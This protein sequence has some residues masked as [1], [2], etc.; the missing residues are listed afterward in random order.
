MDDGRMGARAEQS[1]ALARDAAR[2][3]ATERSDEQEA[4][5]T[6]DIWARLRGGFSL[7][8]A[9]K[10]DVQRQLHWYRRN[11][12][13]VDRVLERASPYL[14]YILT[15]VES[16]GIPSEVALLPAIESAYDPFAYSHGQ[17]SGLWQFIP[18]TARHYGVKQDWW[19]D[20]RRDLIDSTEA[21]LSY[22]LD[23]HRRFDGDWLLALAAYN[24][25]SGTVNKAIRH[26]RQA[27]RPTDFWHL[28]LPAETQSYVPKLLALC[29]IVSTPGG[30]GM[31][32]PSIPDTP[33]IAVIDTGGQLDLGIAA[34]L[35]NIP[36][37]ELYHLNPAHN[38]WAT[39]PEGPHRLVLPVDHAEEFQEALKELPDEKRV[40]WVR[41][42]IRNGETLSHIAHR[43]ATTV[44]LLRETNELRKNTI[45][46]GGHLIVP[47]AVHDLDQYRLS[48]D[49]RRRSRQSTRH[50]SRK[51]AYT[52]KRG[53]SLWSIAR[54]YQVGVRRLAS[55][56]AMAP[57][58]N[59]RAG[60]HLVI[61]QGGGGK[62]ARSGQ[63]RSVHYTVRRGDSLSRI[64]R[65]FR[66]SV[67]DLRRWNDLSKGDYLRPGQRLKLYVD[68]T[69]QSSHSS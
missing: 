67:N 40:H 38:Q 21:A 31:R 63:V 61:W 49:A 8:G 6:P 25:G 55:W 11:T 24:S 69:R 4:P 53:D 52:V 44:S 19:Y 65:N 33:A 48:A 32:L 7:P 23:L 22:L 54:Q 51:I 60:Q 45:R 43:Y 26:N 37:D 34:D 46:A 62:S 50:G 20:G 68:V 15:E 36:L 42:R 1:S 16:R 13:Y 47:V 27:G 64:S 3:L 2:P 9:G 39:H 41:H 14:D 58:D 18:G 28:N 12:E 30:Y 29:E 10:P 35:A 66:V 57:G 5:A 56:N 59:L 17:A